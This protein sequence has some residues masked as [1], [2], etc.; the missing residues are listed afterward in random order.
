MSLLLAFFNGYHAWS[1][2]TSGRVHCVFEIDISSEVQL[3]E[4]PEWNVSSALMEE[5]LYDEI[6]ARTFESVPTF[7]I[8]EKS[9]GTSSLNFIKC[10]ELSSGQKLPNYV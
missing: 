1:S 8:L 3:V 6:K 10:S 7:Q 9:R 4:L 5:R 2:N